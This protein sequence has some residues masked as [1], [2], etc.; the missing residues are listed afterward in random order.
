MSLLKKI[1]LSK[2]LKQVTQEYILP[3]HL[4]TNLQPAYLMFG[5]VPFLNPLNANIYSSVEEGRKLAVIRTKEYHEK[6][7]IHYDSRFAAINFNSKN[8]IIYE[9]F[10]YPFTGPCKIVKRIA[11]VNYEIDLLIFRNKI[12]LIKNI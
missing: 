11:D 3:P 6:S 9:K 12:T 4:V 5:I 10:K 7:K 1:S 2:L 8:F